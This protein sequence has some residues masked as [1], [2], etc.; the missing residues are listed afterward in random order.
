MA[1]DRNAVREGTR[2][3]FDG[4]EVSVQEVT[5]KSIVFLGDCG[6]GLIAIGDFLTRAEDPAISRHERAVK[7]FTRRVGRDPSDEIVCAILYLLERVGAPVP[8][9][10]PAWAEPL[11]KADP[12]PASTIAALSEAYAVPGDVRIVAEPDPLEDY[13]VEIPA[14]PAEYERPV[15]MKRRFR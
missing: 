9:P 4:E 6:L 11:P 15:Q 12:L 3:W 7:L 10:A 8:G 1:V 13:A 5:S 2:W 14:D